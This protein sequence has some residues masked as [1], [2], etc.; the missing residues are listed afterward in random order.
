M[1]Q[2]NLIWLYPLKAWQGQ[3]FLQNIILLYN[4]RSLD[5][6][7]FGDSD[8]YLSRIISS[9]DVLFVRIRGCWMIEAI[10]ILSITERYSDRRIIY[11]SAIADFFL[12]FIHLLVL[13]F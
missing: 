9:E 6:L 2:K 5:L 12:T 7:F 13:W 11:N 1:R 3:F 4:L 10:F 8:E